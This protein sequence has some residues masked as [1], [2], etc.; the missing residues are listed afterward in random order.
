MKTALLTLRIQFAIQ[1]NAFLHYI[2]KLP[3]FRAFL[4]PTVYRY[5]LPK[6]LCCLFGCA[7]GLFKVALP[8]NLFTLILTFYAPQLILR[9]SGR[10][11][12]AGTY[13]FCFF[14]IYCAAGAAQQSKLLRSTREDSLFLNHFMLHPQTW[15]R[16][17]LLTNLCTAALGTLPALIFLF[18]D[19]AMAYF[20]LCANLCAIAAS[21][22]FYLKLFDKKA[23]VPSRKM[24]MLLCTL[25]SLFFYALCGWIRFPV[26][27]Q[28]AL[29]CAGS[30]LLAACGACCA[31]LFRYKGYKAVAAKYASA[32]RPVL[33]IQAVSGAE[34]DD[35]Y[36]KDAPP[37]KNAAQFAQYGSLDAWAYFDRM[38]KIRFRKIR[39]DHFVQIAVLNGA[40]ALFAG[41]LFRYQLFGLQASN[42][43]NYSSF[44][45]TTVIGM[46]WS[47][48]F[49]ELCYR[50][51]DAPLLYHHF[52]DAATIRGSLWARYRYLMKN[53]LYLFG[54]ALLD[55]AILLLAAGT[56]L[57]ADKLLAIAG[58]FA[59]LL[60]GFETLHLAVYYL[61]QP[62]SA[63]NTTKS[64]AFTLIS[65]VE[66][67][68][69]YGILFLRGDIS[70]LLL[71][72]SGFCALV[73]ALLFWAA[74]RAPQTFRF[75]S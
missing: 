17:K 22:L 50:N 61:L 43:L 28:A 30:L 58:I 21:D 29:W 64:P 41:L 39:R 32:N 31:A 36:L 6:L 2:S 26:P 51:M 55:L 75:R 57:P 40:L 18:K 53:A 73:T 67:L 59:L 70:I 5:A 9:I 38:L 49:L 47:H 66:G 52:Y 23:R 42:L 11:A 63:D 14:T 34:I 45:I 16:Q 69:T 25:A 27:P 1:T 74:R 3:V 7:S 13:A 62:Y 19:A 44:A 72:L 68:I 8:G 65:S 12:S 56:W 48:T 71:P 60:L 4:P 54:F 35:L 10:A 33:L 15:Y 24:R 37:E 46:T 20:L